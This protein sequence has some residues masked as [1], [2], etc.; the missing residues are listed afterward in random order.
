MKR[1]FSSNSEPEIAM[2]KGLLE[3]NGIDVLI[4]SEGV[5]NYMRTLGADF[6]LFKDIK[7]QDQDFEKAKELLEENDYSV[8]GDSI[9]SEPTSNGIKWL[10]RVFCILGVLFILFELGMG[11]YYANV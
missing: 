2:V 9:S 1:V 6:N 8:M 7:V 5:G 10:V 11:F 4:T 3:S